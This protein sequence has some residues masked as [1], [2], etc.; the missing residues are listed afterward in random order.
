MKRGKYTKDIILALRAMRFFLRYNRSVNFDPQKHGRRSI[1]L[2][3]Y[4]YSQAGAYYVTVVSQLRKCFFGEVIHGE[5]Q[6]N[7]AGRMI[8]AVWESM[9]QR[10]P[11]VELG[12]FIA[13]PNHFHGIIVIHENVGAGLVPARDDST[14]NRATTRVAP[15][16]N[17]RPTL[18]KVIGAFKSIT[19]HE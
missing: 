8:Q 11:T 9:P 13:M 19:T 6:S 12:A 2:Q 17:S 16:N 3:G 18:G 7:D 14:T 4:D 5:M 15:T 10:F 1:R